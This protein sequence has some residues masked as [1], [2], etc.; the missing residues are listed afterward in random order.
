VVEYKDKNFSKL[1][2]HPQWQSFN[3]VRSGR[4]HDGNPLM[5]SVLEG[6]DMQWSKR[7]TLW[8]FIGNFFCLILF[9]I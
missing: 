3:A 6:F 7:F 2:Q 8:V 4:L 9:V 5:S 1:L